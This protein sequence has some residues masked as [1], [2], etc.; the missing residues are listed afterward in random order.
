MRFLLLG[1][2]TPEGDSINLWGIDLETY[3]VV[4]IEAANHIA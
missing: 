4:N 2:S 1:T 3:S